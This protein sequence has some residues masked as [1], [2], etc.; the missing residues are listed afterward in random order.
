MFLNL[1]LPEIKRKF[2]LLIIIHFL[3]I[4]LVRIWCYINI[5]SMLSLPPVYADGILIFS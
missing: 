2:S 3:L 1:P 4:V 5:I